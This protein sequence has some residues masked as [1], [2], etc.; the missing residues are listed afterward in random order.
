MAKQLNPDVVLVGGGPVDAQQL[1]FWRDKGQLVAVDGGINCLMDKG[2]AP[3]SVIGDMDSADP[4]H[5]ATCR[6]AGIKIT[7]VAD[8]NSTDLEKALHAYPDGLIV[9]LGFLDGRIDHSLAA[10]NALVRA[11]GVGRVLLIGAHDAMIVSNTSLAL[12]LPKAARLSVWPIGQV[13]FASSTG[14][15]WPLDGLNMQVGGQTGT[16][17]KATGDDITIVPDITDEGLYAILVE[18]GDWNALY[19]ALVSS[20]SEASGCG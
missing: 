15:V 17:N 2:C 11:G 4:D 14:L 16:S 9:G 1:A 3:V 18:R 12:S 8:Q 19:D 7:P 6:A 20:K 13:S 5:I 10:L